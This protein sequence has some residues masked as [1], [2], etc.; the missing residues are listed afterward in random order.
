MGLQRQTRVNSFQFTN[1]CIPHHWQTNRPSW[2]EAF[3]LQLSLTQTPWMFKPGGTFEIIRPA[4][5]FPSWGREA[6]G[7]TCSR[8][9]VTKLG[10]QLGCHSEILS[11]M[12]A[13]PLLYFCH[14]T[15]S[16]LLSLFFPPCS[17]VC[18][19]VTVFSAQSAAWFKF[20][21]LTSQILFE[22]IFP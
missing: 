5:L 14:I 2:G 13:C 21:V 4:C 7:K 16:L 6:S 22:K 17:L 18:L 8:S 19:N 12:S 10:I 20:Y 3:L 11:P 1:C 9:Q 15:S